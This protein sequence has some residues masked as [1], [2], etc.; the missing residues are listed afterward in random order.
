MKKIST[1]T[2]RKI[3]NTNKFMSWKFCTFLFL[4]IGVQHV[5]AQNQ[6]FSQQQSN[7]IDTISNI[8]L[9]LQAGIE[10]TVNKSV[11]AKISF[12]AKTPNFLALTIVDNNNKPVRSVMATNE[13]TDA[14][15]ATKRTFDF[16]DVP[17]GTYYATSAEKSTTY[18]KIIVQ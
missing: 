15:N 5:Q 16:T 2:S 14:A 8:P 13:G 10:Y 6:S 12:D 7:G 9:A 3:T 17:A 1:N 18:F 4:V 11:D